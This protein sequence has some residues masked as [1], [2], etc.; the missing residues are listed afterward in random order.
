[1]AAGSVFSGGPTSVADGASFDIRPNP[2]S[3]A[4]VW[5]IYLPE[6]DETVGNYELQWND[7]TPR[8]FGAVTESTLGVPFH[9][10]NGRWI[11][12]KN[13]TLSAQ[14]VGWS[15]IEI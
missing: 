12:V 11:T 3:E 7:G 6:V 4:V 14:Y 8:T 2:G 5:A 10:T 13:L 15:G 1:M 9:V